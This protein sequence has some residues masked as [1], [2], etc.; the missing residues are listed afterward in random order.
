MN[1]ITENVQFNPE[2]EMYYTRLFYSTESKEAEIR[3]GATKKY[4][5][6]LFKQPEDT[7]LNQGYIN[8][9]LKITMRELTKELPRIHQDA[10]SLKMY[11]TNTSEE[12]AGLAFLSA[13]L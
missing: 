1:F 12:E 8:K 3:I 5:Y 13:Q 6:E 2:L 9:W 11:A 4:L 7:V 10:P